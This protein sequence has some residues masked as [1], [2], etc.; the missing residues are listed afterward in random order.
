MDGIGHD[1]QAVGVDTTDEF[2]DREDEV[3]DKRESDV[4][5]I[6]LLVVVIVSHLSCGFPAAAL[7]NGA[8]DSQE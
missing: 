4:L 7:P 8:G 1:G 5:G 2:D 3:Q 6:A